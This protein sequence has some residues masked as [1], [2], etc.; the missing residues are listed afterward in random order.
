LEFHQVKSAKIEEI[1]SAPGRAGA[2]GVAHD[3]SATADQVQEHASPRLPL[4]ESFGQAEGQ[5]GISAAAY[6]QMNEQYQALEV[7]AQQWRQQ[8]EQYAA[9][10]EEWA[11]KVDELE[12]AR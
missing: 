7:E 1:D 2:G 6:E 11:K 10:V 9:V 8:H 3:A 12:E 4:A 5:E